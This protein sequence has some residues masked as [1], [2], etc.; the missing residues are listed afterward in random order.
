MEATIQVRQR[1]TLTLPAEL[2]E[3]YG[4]QAGDSFRLVDLDGVLV[5][6][7]MVPMVPELAREIERMRQEAG[8]STEELLATLREQRQRYYGESYVNDRPE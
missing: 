5:L 2:R 7:P 4:I 8:L 1:G 3:K 6:T